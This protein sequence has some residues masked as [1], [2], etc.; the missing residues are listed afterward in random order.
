MEKERKKMKI[1]R[2]SPKIDNAGSIAIQRSN[3]FFPID[4]APLSFTDIVT[5]YATMIRSNKKPRLFKAALPLLLPPHSQNSV[6]AFFF[7]LFLRNIRIL[8]YRACI[9]RAT[10]EGPFVADQLHAILLS[11]VR[12]TQIASTNTWISVP[13]LVVSLLARLWKEAVAE[14][15][16][17]RTFDK[18]RHR[19]VLYTFAR[20]NL[21]PVYISRERTQKREK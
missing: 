10:L 19:H 20:L 8:L 7:F 2:G 18:R 1:Q 12:K 14:S 11:R 17:C 4:R 6:S 9:P 15:S 16:R 13:L 21:Y 5:F 3:K